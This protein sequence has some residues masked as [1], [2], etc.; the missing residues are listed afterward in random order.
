MPKKTNA[1]RD[2]GRIAVQVYL[3]MV[4]GK[5]KYKTVYGATQKE[6]DEKALQVKLSMK[7]G[8][9]VTAGRDTFKKWADRFIMRKKVDV[10]ARQVETYQSYL[11]H[12]NCLNDIPIS[13]IRTDDIQSILDEL[14]T[15]SH[16]EGGPLAK[17]TLH[18]LKYTASQIFRLAQVGRVISE[19]P[20]TAATV[21]KDAAVSERRALT[22]EEQQWIVDTPHRAQRAAMIMMYAGL[23]R[24]ELIPLTWGDINLDARTIKINKAVEMVK[25]KPVPKDMTKTPA[26]LRTIT[27]PQ[28]LVNFL[29]VEHDTIFSNARAMPWELV[30]K[31]AHGIMINS[32][33]WDC[34]WKSYMRD[35]NAKYGAFTIKANK[36]RPGGLPMMLPPITAHWLR[37][38]F[39]T[40]LYLAGVDVLTARDQLGHE[41]VETTLRIYTHLDK[42]YKKR[43]M[44]KLDNYLQCKSDASQAN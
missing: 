43:A 4:D 32:R 22:D 21:P 15:R 31:S 30:C 25:G 28:R 42:I 23:R 9:D 8:I 38:T 17:K 37:H 13:K 19:N 12:F 3:G 35:L 36:N 6:A 27:I 18:D 11:R 33:A 2:D 44:D 41:D 5:R 29:Q 40:L 7:K 14:A 26:G 39:A 16:H 10:S 34:L 24:G 20:A 1:K